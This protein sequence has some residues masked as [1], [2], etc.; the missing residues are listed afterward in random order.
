MLNRPR[1]LNSCVMHYDLFLNC[2]SYPSILKMLLQLPRRVDVEVCTLHRLIFSSLPSP[3]VKTR[4]Y[5]PLIAI[6]NSS[7]A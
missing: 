5:T 1:G 2:R 3:A 4:N 6:S 7:A